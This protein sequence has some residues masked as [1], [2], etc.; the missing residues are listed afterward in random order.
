M[1]LYNIAFTGHRDVESAD[2]SDVHANLNDLVRAV[3]NV[4]FHS[5]GASGFDTVALLATA[6]QGG[7]PHLL[8]VPFRYQYNALLLEF[9]LLDNELREYTSICASCGIKN[10][11][12]RP[13]D[14]HLY[15]KRNEHMVDLAD[16][17]I[18]Y[19]DGKEQGS[20]TWNTIKYAR[21]VGKKVTD[22]RDL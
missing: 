18:C 19:W 17:V 8:H 11:Y 13:T 15:Q 1:K 22:I 10:D 5:G 3:P 9:N 7:A 12:I 4:T 21:K 14:N 6:I 20:G 16:E 2:L